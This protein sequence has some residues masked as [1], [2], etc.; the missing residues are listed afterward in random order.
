MKSKRRIL[1]LVVT[2]IMLLSLSSCVRQPAAPEKQEVSSS[3]GKLFD[4]PVTIKVALG[5]HP[6]WPYDENYKAWQY[7]REGTG[8]NFDVQAIPNTEYGTKVTLMLASPDTLPDLMFCDSKKFADINGPSGA[9]LPVDDYLDKLPNYTAFWNSIPEDERVELMNQRRSG[10]GKIYFPPNY[11]FHTI[12][13]TRAWLYRADIF[14]K[15]NLKIP[16]TINE[17]YDTAMKL[18]ELYPESYPISMR[19]G[20]RNLGNM[21]PQWAPYFAPGLYYDFNTETWHYGIIEDTMRQMVE[22]MIKFHK[23]GVLPPDYL[24]INTKTWEELVFNDKGFMM[25]EYVV[26]VDF[27]QNPAR[28]QNPDFTLKVMP[29]PKADTPT[30]QHKMSKQ[31]Y[32]MLGYV[33]PNTRDETRIN[34]TMKVFDWMYSEEGRELLSWGKEGETYKVV[35]GK[36]RFILDEGETAYAKYGFATYGLGQCIYAEANEA[37]YSDDQSEQSR[38]A[39][40]YGEKYMNPAQWLAFTDDTKNE[41]DDI[42]SGIDVFTNEMLSKF[43]Y[44][45]EPMSKWDAFVEEVKNSGVE[46]L[47]AYYSEAYKKVTGK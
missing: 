41:V 22:D 31:N 6:S 40:G 4:E 5:S 33:L 44:G 10:D 12:G 30:G 43:L 23:A 2:I 38:I 25:P 21:G 27:F 9:L 47:L 14:E 26:R 7:F 24:K 19:E 3:G 42:L 35:D 45:I 37:L 28:E 32:E 36:R 8:A 15:H 17:L 13:N 34:N 11:G 46:E 16:E 18:K 1:A 20:L 39:I 29:P